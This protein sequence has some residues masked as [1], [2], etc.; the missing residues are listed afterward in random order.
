MAI[1]ILCS[2]GF[3]PRELFVADVATAFPWVVTY[4]IRADPVTPCE[5]RDTT[6]QSRP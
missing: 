5:L 4:G 6:S 1:S 2:I 3:I